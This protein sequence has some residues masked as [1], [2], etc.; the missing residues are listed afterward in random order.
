MLKWVLNIEMDKW[1]SYDGQRNKSHGGI[2]TVFTRGSFPDSQ[3]IE[4]GHMVSGL[5]IEDER[6]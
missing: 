4:R 1:E 6:W 5:S 2:N 3:N